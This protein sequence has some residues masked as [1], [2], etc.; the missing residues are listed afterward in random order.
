MGIEISEL[1]KQEIKSEITKEEIS[2]NLKS[3][4][5]QKSPGP[6]GIPIDFYIMF[7]PKLQD[8]PEILMKC[9]VNTRN[10]HKSARRGIISLIPKKGCDLLYVKNWRLIILLNADYKLFSK[11]LVTRLQNILDTIIHNDQ[12]GFMPGRNISHNL[13]KTLDTIT[14]IQKRKIDAILILLDFEKA[15]DRLEYK[16]LYGALRAFG[17]PQEYIDN[18]EILFTDFK[19]ATVNGGFFSDWF[20][21]SREVFQGNCISPYT[22][23]T[24]IKILAIRLRQNDNIKGIEINGLI[25]LLTQFAD[26]MQM[27]MK[28]LQKSL[29]ATIDELTIFEGISGMKVNYDKTAIYHIGSLTNSNAKLYVS[30]EFQWMTEP[31]VILGLEVSNAENQMCDNN[32]SELIKKAENVLHC[33]QVCSLSICGKIQVLN[34]LVASLFVYRLSVLPC[35]TQ[36][37]LNRLD[38][39]FNSFIWDDKRPK[40][41]LETLAAPKDNSGLGL[42][43][44]KVKDQSLKLQWVKGIMSDPVMKMLAYELMGSKIGYLL[45][46]C[47]FVKA[48]IGYILPQTSS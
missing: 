8:Y 27:F 42:M 9:I 44:M 36:N 47:Q 28:F 20:S 15:F 45:W 22:L 12:M 5:Q 31:L 46:K 4:R 39:M 21:P 41:K 1:Q 13:W 14:Y 3:F 33:W 18:I 38:K 30:R 25:N 24:V 16:S 11:I 32:Y 23:T 29:Q 10:L 34:S 48:D 37:M 43:N 2:K 40:V 7:W 26:N 6:D 19:L 17:I 35:F